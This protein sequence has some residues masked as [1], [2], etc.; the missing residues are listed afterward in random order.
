MATSAVDICNGALGRL[1]QDV[2]ISAL[3]DAT[4]HARA[5]NAVFQRVVDYVFSD[6]VWPFTIKQVAL[7]LLGDGDNGWVYRYAYPSDCMTAIAL[8]DGT[9]ARRYRDTSAS[10]LGE[11]PIGAEY[12]VVYGDNNAAAILTDLEGAWLVYSARVNEIGRYPP[13]FVDALICRLAV[14]LAPVIAGDVGIRM[15]QMLEQKYA[16][17]RDHALAH[18]MNESAEVMLGMVTPT[19]AARGA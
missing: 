8:T 12:E 1:G 17:A 10:S 19:M 3:S 11:T 7:S 18:N 9:G 4:K 15:L 2:R 16:V 13:L 6:A 5:C 14:E